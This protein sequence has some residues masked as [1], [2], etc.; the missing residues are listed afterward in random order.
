MSLRIGIFHIRCTFEDELEVLHITSLDGTVGS[1][2][3]HQMS[4][5]DQWFR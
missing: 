5:L 3:D 1:D 4:P 2:L